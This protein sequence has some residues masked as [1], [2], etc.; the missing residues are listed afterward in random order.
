[1]KTRAYRLPCS[2]RLVARDLGM[3]P[4]GFAGCRLSEQDLDA[5]L[6]TK[7]LDRLWDEIS[8]VL[9]ENAS[10]ELSRRIGADSLHPAWLACLTS[11]HLNAA[12]TRLASIQR[13]GWPS[14][15]AQ[16]SSLETSLHYSPGAMPRDLQ[17]ASLLVWVFAVRRLTGC[18]VRPLALIVPDTAG[19]NPIADVLMCKLEDG[20]TYGLRFASLDG[21]RPFLTAAGFRSLSLEQLIR[22]SQP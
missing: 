14:L 17:V 6:T 11:E 9:G 15:H 2:W 10:V 8:K 12:A 1:M 5:E 22:A 21:R 18:P 4:T 13:P 3:S 7:D 19:L 20:S 16:L